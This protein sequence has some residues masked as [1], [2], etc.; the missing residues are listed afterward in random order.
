MAQC[1]EM[2]KEGSDKRQEMFKRFFAWLRE[3]PIDKIAK[4]TERYELHTKWIAQQ[5]EAREKGMG[6]GEVK[7][8]VRREVAKEKEI[9]IKE[10]PAK[11]EPVVREYPKMRAEE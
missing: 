5:R 9:G 2:R 10:E 7:E 6:L 3:H 8:E 4:Y 1:L 11:M